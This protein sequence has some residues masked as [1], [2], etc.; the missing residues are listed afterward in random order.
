[1]P[2]DK[3]ALFTT[4]TLFTTAITLAAVWSAPETSW[5]DQELEPAGSSVKLWG[6]VVVGEVNPSL[7][8]A[9]VAVTVVVVAVVVPALVVLT[10]V[11]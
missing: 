10:V 2:V 3:P 8:D 6:V 7:N 1:M 5:Y 9:G 11:M 4:P